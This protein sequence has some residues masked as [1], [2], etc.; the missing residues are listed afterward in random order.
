[1]PAPK[2]KLIDKSAQKADA[3]AA[4]KL[5]D[6][7]DSLPPA[8]RILVEDDYRD[9]LPAHLTPLTFYSYYKEYVSPDTR[10]L[11]FTADYLLAHDSNH[12]E[13]LLVPPT[14]WEPQL[15]VR[16]DSEQRLVT[17]CKRGKDITLE[18][19]AM[20][21]APLATE[22]AIIPGGILKKK[23]GGVASVSYQIDRFR[24]ERFEVSHGQFASFLNAQNFNAL[25]FDAIY[26][27][28]D[29]ASKIVFFEGKFRVFKGFENIPV[30]NVSWQ[31]ADAFCKYHKRHLPTVA[32]WQIAAGV[33]K[34]RP[35]PWGEQID[36]HNRTNLIGNQDGYSLLAPVDSFPQGASPEKVHN[37]FGNVYE[38]VEKGGLLGGPFNLVMDRDRFISPDSSDPL[39]R[40]ILNGFR[41][42]K[43]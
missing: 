35:Y 15:S 2:D 14:V 30:F 19:F 25:E 40:N 23:A 8:T 3:L 12:M 36:F 22:M 5:T 29:P 32:Q 16:F 17:I 6:F 38:W 20:P 28:K 1:L 26:S 41:C 31:G 21:S 24:L 34:K 11:P 37:L 10:V 4:K 13:L 42:A 27:T 43:D 7:L 18:M 39:S 9:L 33:G